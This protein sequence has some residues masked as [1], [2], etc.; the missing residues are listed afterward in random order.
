[1]SIKINLIPEAYANKL[2][3]ER[4]RNMLLS[5][6]VL[7]TIVGV[8][9]NISL[10][11]LFGTKNY[12]KSTID[13]KISDL[14]AE[15]NA[16]IVGKDGSN[17]DYFKEYV[18]MSNRL[19]INK[20]LTSNRYYLSENIDELRKLI[21]KSKNIEIIT[22]KIDAGNKV[23]LTGTARPA[24]GETAAALVG[25]F[26]NRIKEYSVRRSG[27]KKEELMFDGEV[28]DP[29]NYNPGPDG[30]YPFTITTRLN[31]KIFRGK[32][33]STKTNVGNN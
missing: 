22:V 10:L 28:S 3:T 2:K 30:G 19:T 24:A 29:L 17:I 16:N 33:I 14:E 11:G 9:A 13:K 32:P 21:D 20:K 25:D 5:L 4:L 23:T 8:V 6:A 18:N 27:A 7:S 1:M 12:Q 31:E 26:R 15:V